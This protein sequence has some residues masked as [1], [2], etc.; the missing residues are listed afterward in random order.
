MRESEA[1]AYLGVSVR[2]LHRYRKAG[3]LTCQRVPAGVGRPVIDYDEQELARFKARSRPSVVAAETAHSP[4]E[5]G[6]GRSPRVAFGLPRGEH[7]ELREEASRYGMSP[8]EYARRLVREGLESRLR[9][10][11]EVLRGEAQAV[12]ADI[13]RLRTEVAGAFEV[14]LEYVGIPPEEARQW[15]AQNL[16]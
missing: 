2:S 12:R 1:A 9:R 3:K 14:V 8:G 16:R 15:V 11:T 10:E 13:K 7:A 5:T 6:A 4:P